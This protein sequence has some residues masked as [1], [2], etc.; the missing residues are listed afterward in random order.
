MIARGPACAICGG[1]IARLDCRVRKYC[2]A[3]RRN[4]SN[5]VRSELLGT[6]LTCVECG[7]EFK[8][9]PSWA[10]KIHRCPACRGPKPRPPRTCPT[11]QTLFTP[12]RVTQKYCGRLCR[13]HVDPRVTFERLVQKGDGCWFWKG[14]ISSARDQPWFKSRGKTISARRLGYEIYRGPLPAGCQ[15]RRNLSCPV[16]CVNPFHHERSKRSLTIKD[17]VAQSDAGGAQ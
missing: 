13:H 2:L 4:T 8:T 11:C 12:R 6:S 1:A 3:C 17:V 15:L 16:T 5:K 7:G 14:A 10:H 9:W